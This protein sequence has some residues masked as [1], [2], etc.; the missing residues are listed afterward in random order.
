MTPPL[1]CAGHR[2]M[3]KCRRCVTVCSEIQAVG[4]LFPQNRGYSSV[5]GPAFAARLRN[6]TCTMRQCAA[7]CPVGAIYERSHIEPVLE[8]LE[9]PKTCCCTDCASHTRSFGRMFR[10]SAWHLVT[11]KMVTALRELGFNAV[12]DT[13]F[14]ADLTIMEETELLRLKSAVRTARMCRF[15]CLQAALRA[16]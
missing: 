8:A 1:S 13:N 6:V 10:I 2:Q 11:G 5:I 4:A 15:Q 3:H 9:D 7:I 14:A 16:G 12:F